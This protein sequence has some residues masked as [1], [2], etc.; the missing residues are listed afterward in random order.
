MSERDKLNDD[1]IADVSGYLTKPV[2]SD[3]LAA[4][5]SALV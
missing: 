3:E 2:G 5:L 4:A 1:R